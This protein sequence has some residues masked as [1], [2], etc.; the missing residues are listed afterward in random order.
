MG[1]WKAMNPLAFANKDENVVKR[2]TATTKRCWWK[3]IINEESIA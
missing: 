1:C 2:L 3:C